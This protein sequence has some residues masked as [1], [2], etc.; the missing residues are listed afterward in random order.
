MAK[1][2]PLFAWCGG[3]RL[4]NTFIFVKWHNSD[5]I[6]HVCVYGK[7]GVYIDVTWYIVNEANRK[8]NGD[9]IS[10]K[11]LRVVFN[12]YFQHDRIN[13]GMGLI[14]YRDQDNHVKESIP[15]NFMVG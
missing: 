8:I 4:Q 13:I 11:C 7:I 2:E 14:L 15:Y 6:V 12:W 10:Q 5:T 3:A 1:V 9:I